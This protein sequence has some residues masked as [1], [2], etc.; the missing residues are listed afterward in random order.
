MKLN[1]YLLSFHFIYFREK[2]SM[3]GGGVR[4]GAEGK[5]EAGSTLSM[6]QGAQ[7]HDTGI[8]T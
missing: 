2:V 6:D 4:E 8:M 1:G 5:R 3:S 7:S